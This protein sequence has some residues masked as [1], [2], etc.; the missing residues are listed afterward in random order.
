MALIQ[1]R[2]RTILDSLNS[3]LLGR[4]EVMNLTFLSAIAGERKRWKKEKKKKF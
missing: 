3:G 2:I 4:E 1:P